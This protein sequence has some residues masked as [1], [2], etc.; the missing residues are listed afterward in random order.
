[1]FF[2]DECLTEGRALNSER[3]LKS[4]KDLQKVFNEA[5]AAEAKGDMKLANKKYKETKSAIKT[6]I[7]DYDKMPEDDFWDKIQV[8]VVSFLL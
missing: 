6:L 4:F 5:K 2:N 1:M 8:F 3:E 7:N